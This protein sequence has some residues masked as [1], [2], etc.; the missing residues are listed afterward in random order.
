[1]IAEA[2]RVV[3]PI[4]VEVVL[5]GIFLQKDGQLQGRSVTRCAV[6]LHQRTDGPTEPRNECALVV[7]VDP[8]P[9]GDPILGPAS[10]GIPK[11]IESSKC[12]PR[13]LLARVPS[14][15]SAPARR[16][17]GIPSRTLCGRK[18]SSGPSIRSRFSGR[19]SDPLYEKKAARACFSTASS[20]IG[21]PRDSAVSSALRCRPGT[22]DSECT[23]L[24]ARCGS[25]QTCEPKKGMSLSSALNTLA[26]VRQPARMALPMSVVLTWRS[27]MARPPAHGSMAA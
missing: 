13:L 1:M 2:I 19:G 18:F 16:A 11:P 8:V 12:W 20:S 5:D 21:K 27:F 17:R 4:G 10:V 3:A 15:E 6:V 22:C 9:G 14:R 25:G 23:E 24:K 26:I 7:E